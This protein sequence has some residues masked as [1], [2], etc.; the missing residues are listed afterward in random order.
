LQKVLNQ[1]GRRIKSLSSDEIKLDKQIKKVLACKPILSRILLEVVEECEGMTPEEVER[2]IE[3]E[4]LVA[5]LFVEPGFT[6]SEIIAGENQ[7]D[8]ELG[9][10][11]VTYD[12]RTSLIIPNKGGESERHYIKILIDVEAQKDDTPGYPISLRAMFYCSRMVSSQLGTEFDNRTSDKEKYGNLKKVY[13]IW[14]CTETAQKRANTIEKLSIN[15]E[16]LVGRHDD[17][18]R[19]DLMTAII[20]N[21]SKTHNTG[22]TDNELICMLTDLLNE[23]M[24]ADDKIDILENRY[25]IPMTEEIK[26]EVDEMLAYTANIK[27]QGEA[28]GRADGMAEGISEGQIKLIAATKDARAGLSYEDLVAKY[29]EETAKNALLM[30]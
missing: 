19:Y 17:E 10:G 21:I 5:R 26:E 18:E 24:S 12:I 8:F 27:K 23:D 29:G 20:I 15:R 6:N 22:G 3:G 14:I 13:S 16:F 2:C 30:K 7:E 11:L 25:H 9:E 4:V 28:K 1:T